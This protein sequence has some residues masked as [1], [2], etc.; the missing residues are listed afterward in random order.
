MSAQRDS[1]FQTAEKLQPTDYYAIHYYAFFRMKLHSSLKQSCD[2]SVFRSVSIALI[3]F[4]ALS[5]SACNEYWRTRGQ[6]P[7]V[8]KLLERSQSRLSEA[9]E[10]NETSRTE[11]SLLSKKIEK[12][13]L[14]VAKSLESA[15]AK[16]NGQ[17]LKSLS[18]ASDNFIALEG[19]VSIGSRAALGELAGQMRTFSETASQGNSL[20]PKAFGLFT[21]RTMFF[22]ANELSV[23]GPN[24]G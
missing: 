17:L 19:K 8:Q 13:L 14:A 20:A 3:L 9:R 2:S 4:S 6:P 22:L 15:E 7:S 18:E 12:S 24:F 5:L 11:L 10:E 21:A 1:L 16:E 23:P